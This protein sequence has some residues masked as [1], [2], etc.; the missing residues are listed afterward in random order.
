MKPFFLPPK[1]TTASLGNSEN[2][3]QVTFKTFR[4]RRCCL[5]LRRLLCIKR[6][7]RCKSLPLLTLSQHVLYEEFMFLSLVRGLANV[8]VLA[9]SGD[10]DDDDDYN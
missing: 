3:S 1:S 5:R 8:A 4:M 2:D 9:F 6:P 10:E 7:F